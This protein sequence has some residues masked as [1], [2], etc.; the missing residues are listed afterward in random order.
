M[1]DPTVAAQM[2]VMA[3]IRTGVTAIGQ[4]VHDVVP[5]SA[6]FPYITV[7]GPVG[8]PIDE[9]CWDRSELTFQLDVWSNSAN[10]NEAK[11]I[12]VVVRGLFHETT[13]PVDGFAIDRCRVTSSTPSR[14]DA[15]KLHRVRVMVTMELQPA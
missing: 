10:S 5:Q 6:A 8:I 12:G 4:R 11:T 7:Q 9:E 13:F 2:A 3:R 1:S 15:T 14:E